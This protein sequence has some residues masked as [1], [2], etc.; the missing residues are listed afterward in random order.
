MTQK[1]CQRGKPAVAHGFPTIFDRQKHQSN[2]RVGSWEAG[3]GCIRE[4]GVA[5]QTESESLMLSPRSM[6][7][8]RW[9]V[10]P[11]RPRSGAGFSGGC[12]VVEE[13]TLVKTEVRS[14]LIEIVGVVAWLLILASILDWL[15]G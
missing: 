3:S 12:V 1:P 7:P 14:E 2:R 6:V 11:H 4:R 13:V 5:Q 10:L 8:S 15:V 9:G